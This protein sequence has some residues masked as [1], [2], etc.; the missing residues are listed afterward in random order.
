MVVQV[1]QVMFPLASKV[2]GPVAETAT[3]PVAFG[4]VM[5]L[6]E[7][8]GVAK[9]SVLVKAPV[10]LLM[11]TLAPWTVTFWLVAPSR[12]A[13]VG[14]IVLTPSVPPIVTTAPD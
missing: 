11:L 2:I 7:P 4:T 13:A 1:A 9:L 12:K 3:V 10:V 14:V 8:A 6:L 5:V